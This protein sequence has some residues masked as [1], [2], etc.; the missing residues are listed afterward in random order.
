MYNDFDIGQHRVYRS[1]DPADIQSLETNTIR[2]VEWPETQRDSTNETR[3]APEQVL[4]L[5][6]TLPMEQ[7]C[8]FW[9]YQQELEVS[10]EDPLVRAVCISTTFN[11]LFLIWI[12]SDTILRRLCVIK[13]PGKS[14]RFD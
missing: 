11:L 8:L 14:P 12:I 3:H 7:R 10:W 9:T 13:R 2:S 4:S 6:S 1:I 5:K